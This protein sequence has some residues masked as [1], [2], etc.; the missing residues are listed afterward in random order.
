MLS[1]EELILEVWNILK[2]QGKNL[3]LAIFI[4]IVLLLLLLLAV[5][6]LEVIGDQ[7][8]VLKPEVQIIL[9]LS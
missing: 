7:E 5:N 6:L 8:L 3:M 4:L 2:K 9:K 1:L